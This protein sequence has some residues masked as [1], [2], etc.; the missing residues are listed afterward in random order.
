[1]TALPNA[2]GW[3]SVKWDNGHSNSYRWGAEGKRDLTILGGGVIASP[4]VLALRARFNVVVFCDDAAYGDRVVAALKETGF[5]QANRQG[6]P[7]AYRNIKYGKADETT[8]DA[9]LDL[10]SARFGV[11][12]R[13]ARE[14]VFSSYDDD[15]FINLP[16]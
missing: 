12:D 6:G 13:I 1:V 9:I 3:C 10:L 11:R 14:H 4:A 8:V 2:N 15:I 7:N 5:A 16:E